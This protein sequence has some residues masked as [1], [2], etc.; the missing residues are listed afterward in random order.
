MQTANKLHPQLAFHKQ[1][2]LWWPTDTSPDAGFEYMIRRVTDVDVA[3]KLCRKT[4]VAVQAGG[5]VG[6]WPLRLAKFF[7]CVHTFEAVPNIFAAL[8]VNIERVPGVIA[9]NSLLSSEMGRVVPFSIR[10]GGVSR[11]VADVA[12]A[13]SSFTAVTIDSLKLPCCDAIFL[14]VEGHELDALAGARE[15]IQKWRPVITVEV[16]NDN[17]KPYADWFDMLGYER[18]VKVHGDYIFAPRE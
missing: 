10:S 16:W 11:A 1:S 4:A 2:G 18:K 9:H 3:V 5:N 17:E 8:S 6:M 14:D 7:S 12:A 15:T 13:N